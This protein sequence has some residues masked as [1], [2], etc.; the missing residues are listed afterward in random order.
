MSFLH[1]FALGCVCVQACKAVA[2][3]KGIQT[4]DLSSNQLSVTGAAALA[5]ALWRCRSLHEIV[6]EESV[7][8]KDAE[9]VSCERGLG[10][11][12]RSCIIRAGG[13]WRERDACFHDRGGWTGGL[14]ENETTSSPP[15]GAENTNRTPCLR[16]AVVSRRGRASIL[17]RSPV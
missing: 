4:L 2:N 6:L 10:S 7:D 14:G 5:K 16:K 1:S 8:P 11:Y 9:K 3:M 15:E 13:S 12:V 17:R